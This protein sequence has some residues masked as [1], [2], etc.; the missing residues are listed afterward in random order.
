MTNVQDIG[1]A[2]L[3]IGSTVRIEFESRENG[4][5]IPQAILSNHIT[6]KK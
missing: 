5:S 1:T 3:R 2:E 6:S 4:V